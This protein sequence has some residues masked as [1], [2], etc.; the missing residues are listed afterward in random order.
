MLHSVLCVCRIYLCR[1][2]VCR[3][4]LAEAARLSAVNLY[5]SLQAMIAVPDDRCLIE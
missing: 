2:Y 5:R 4:S 1:I 3:V